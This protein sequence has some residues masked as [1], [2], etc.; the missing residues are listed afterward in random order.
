VVFGKLA[1]RRFSEQH[2]K[3]LCYA[4]ICS[5]AG[6]LGNPVA[7][8]VFGATGLMYA[9]V[10]LIPLRIMMWSEGIAT[11]SGEKDFRATAKKVLTHPCIISCAIG[12]VMMLGSIPMPAL[13]L[14]PIQTIAKCNTAL[15]MLVIGMILSD[16]DL[17]TMVNKEVLLFTFCRLV[18]IPLLIWLCT[19]P[20]SMS[21][22]ARGICVLLAAMPA[23]ATT[24]MLANKYDCDP[25]F[26]TKLV[27]F[28]TLCSIPAILGWC[29][30]LA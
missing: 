3:C 7:E 26:G 16:V 4:T 2:R 11:F 30:V 19:L 17:K 21:E 1:F 18:V 6:F 15:S 13:L 9:S 29:L 8:G 12:I 22:T 24:S 27:V 10:Y 25:A 20:I 5:N 28:S 14:T 23:G